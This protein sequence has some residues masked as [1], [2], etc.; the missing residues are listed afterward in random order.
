M[1]ATIKPGSDRTI[2]NRDGQRAPILY[3]ETTEKLQYLR[4]DG[5]TGAPM[6]IDYAHHETHDGNSFWCYQNQTIDL[7]DVINIGAT[8]PN[9]EKWL[10][11]L[12]DVRATS[13]ATFS[14][15]E[16]CTA[17]AGGNG[18][19]TASNFNRNSSNAS[20]A[21]FISGYTDLNP[22]TATGGN[23]IWDE[24]LN[25]AIKVSTSR[26]NNTEI[27]M[28]QNSKYLFEVTSAGNGNTIT[29]LLTWY[30]HTNRS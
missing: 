6:I 29:L 26:Q 3:N 21:G 27:I 1:S 17:L 24:I 5:I 30:E 15:L 19:A 4:T 12:L 18:A 2:V 14:I 28:K 13:A 7:G 20:G 8:M 16:D 9:T 10:H 25:T 22:V 23:T 11:L